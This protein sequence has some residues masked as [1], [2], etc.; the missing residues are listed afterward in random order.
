MALNCRNFWSCITFFYLLLGNFHKQGNFVLGLSTNNLTF[1]IF[2]C[3]LRETGLFGLWQIHHILKIQKFREFY[4]PLLYSSLAAVLFPRNYVETFV[5]DQN[6]PEFVF[7]VTAKFKTNL[8]Q[9][10]KAFFLQNLR[11]IFEINL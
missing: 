11:E 5:Y 1:F 6:R 8:T 2:W 9:S 4:P 3:F 7:V 10:F